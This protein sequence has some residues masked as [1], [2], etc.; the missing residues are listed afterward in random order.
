[1]ENK[2]VYNNKESIKEKKELLLEKKKEK[3]KKRNKYP[4]IFSSC[5]N[6]ITSAEM[7]TIYAERRIKQNDYSP[8][9]MYKDWIFNGNGKDFNEAVEAMEFFLICSNY[10]DVFVDE[11]N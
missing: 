4:K 11:N 5:K 10:P 6:P 8:F 3:S 1:M 2:S 7:A 9:G